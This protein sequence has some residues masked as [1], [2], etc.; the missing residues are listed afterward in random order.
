MPI[1]LEDTYSMN[2]EVFDGRD[3]DCIAYHHPFQWLSDTDL[4]PV[5]YKYIVTEWLCLYPPWET[6]NAH[7]IPKSIAS[8][9]NL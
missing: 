8:S 9:S 1:S 4:L 3:H 6:Q 5:L 2:V 7:L